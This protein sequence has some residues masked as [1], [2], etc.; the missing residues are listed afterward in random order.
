MYVFHKDIPNQQWNVFEIVDGHEI[1]IC[2]FGTLV[3]AQRYC[4]RM[5]DAIATEVQKRLFSDALSG[6][7]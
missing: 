2:S 1:Y 7:E 4:N 3:E 5:N 6:S